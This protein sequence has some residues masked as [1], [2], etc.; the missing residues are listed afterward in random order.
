MIKIKYNH[1]V[2]IWIFL[3]I[4][5]LTFILYGV[6]PTVQNKTKW[7]PEWPLTYAMVFNNC[8]W[9]CVGY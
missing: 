2:L 6:L 1:R 9:N 4:I 3:L 8:N 5:V 7:N